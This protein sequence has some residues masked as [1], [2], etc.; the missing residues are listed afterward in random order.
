MD[1]CR[2]VVAALLAAGCCRLAAAAE[3]PAA[4]TGGE[5]PKLLWTLDLKS[6]SYGGGALAD[7]Q[8]DGTQVW[9]FGTY[10]NDEHLYAVRARDGHV[11]WKFRSEGGP[12]DAS[13]AIADLDGNGRLD[14]LAADSST[15]TLF[16]LDPLGRVQWKHRLP[17]STDS[18]PAVADLNGDGRLEIVV[19]TMAQRDTQG[20]VVVLDARTRQENWRVAVPGHVQSEPAL[21]DLNGD[22]T[23]DVIVT[24]WRG[25]KSV[26]ALDGRDGARL[27]SHRLAGDMYHGVS[28]FRDGGIRILAASIAGDVCLLDAAGQP[29]WNRQ[30]GGYLFGPTTVADLDGDGRAELIVAGGRLHVLDGAGTE[31]W[32]TPDF[33]S[34]ARGAVAVDVNGDEQRDVL[35]GSSD[36]KFRAFDGRT[37]RELWSYDATVQG[38]VYEFFDSAPL[39]ADADQD[40]V[41]EAFFVMGKGTSDKTRNENYG[42]AVALKVGRGQGDWT[43]FRGSLQRCGTR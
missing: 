26:H 2:L 9:V 31:R 32:R 8:G 11:L 24:T 41:L 3:L 16:C 34:I 28:A 23:L 17:N 20:R 37:G 38:H 36:R 14:V 40:G 15:G 13:V 1:R 43:M 7:L 29:L 22:Q 35:C 10:F 30:L 25:D 18:P 21:V 39:V 12:F 5:F 4:A 6:A 19:G 27:W 33:R 42:R